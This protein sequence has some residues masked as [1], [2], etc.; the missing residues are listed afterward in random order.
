MNVSIPYIIYTTIINYLHILIIQEN[1]SNCIGEINLI[2]ESNRI[3]TVPEYGHSRYLRNY[4][5]YNKI[6]MNKIFII[7]NNLKEYFLF[8]YYTKY[9]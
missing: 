4:K 3:Q 8:L 5:S 9:C 1:L 7:K 6:L 2:G